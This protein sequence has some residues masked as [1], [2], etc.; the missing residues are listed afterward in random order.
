MNK[1]ERKQKGINKWV[2]RLK[3]LSLW[4]KGN[5]EPFT[6]CWKNQAVVC[7]C[8][9]CS[10]DKFKRHEKHKKDIKSEFYGE[11][12]HELVKELNNE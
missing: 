11:F 3:N 10:P 9:M 2:K 4:N 8:D 5:P 1:Q 6:K 7:S 12:H